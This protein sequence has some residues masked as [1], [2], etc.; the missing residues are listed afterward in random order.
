MIRRPPRSTRTDT[1][2]P[3][4]TLFRSPHLHLHLQDAPKFGEGNGMPVF[5]EHYTANGKAVA[6]GEP[7]KGQ[8]VAPVDGGTSEET[9]A[10]TRRID[11]RTA[12]CLGPY[13][14]NNTTPSTQHHKLLELQEP[15]H[16]SIPVRAP[17]PYHTPYTPV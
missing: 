1:L 16:Y 10:S 14:P 17:R 9:A 13:Q 2:F 6:R 4:T 5:F 7:V 12:F 15:E 11:V 8:T 3:Y